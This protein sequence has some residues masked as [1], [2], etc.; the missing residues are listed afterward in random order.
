MM[1]LL[2]LL[3]KVFDVKIAIYRVVPESLGGILN[4]GILDNWNNI[5]CQSKRTSVKQLNWVLEKLCTF[6]VTELDDS[7]NYFDHVD[8]IPFTAKVMINY[9]V[10]KCSQ[11][12]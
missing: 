7:W 12:L 9:L 5:H 3:K 10:I 4:Q 11:L 2:M 1:L 6:F 8:V